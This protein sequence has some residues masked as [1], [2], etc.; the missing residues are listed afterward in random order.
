MRF[1]SCW[2]ALF[3]FDCAIFMRLWAPSVGFCWFSSPKLQ[4]FF[5]QSY[6][7]IPVNSVFSNLSGVLFPF[8]LGIILSS[9]S[10]NCQE[11]FVTKGE[12][13]IIICSFF[14][15]FHCNSE[16]FLLHVWNVE[17]LFRVFAE[18]LFSPNIFLFLQTGSFAFT[19]FGL[20]IFWYEKASI[21][22]LSDA[23]W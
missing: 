20:H 22:L 16:D 3:P 23:Q 2:L 13:L 9:D 21:F 12:M 6:K 18:M 17:E 15:W 4:S 8:F 14:F 5:H 19:L 10:E 7:K 1:C 11:F